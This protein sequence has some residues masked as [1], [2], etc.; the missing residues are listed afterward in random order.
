MGLANRFRV[1]GL[2]TAGQTYK[3]YK[4][5]GIK[6]W[7]R[8]RVDLQ[9]ILE[10]RIGTMDLT[11]QEHADAS[12]SQVL[13]AAATPS[14][15]ILQP[16]RTSS[17]VH[18]VGGQASV[19]KRVLAI[20]V[21]DDDL[22]RKRAKSYSADGGRCRAE[23]SS[24]PSQCGGAG[25]GAVI[26]AH[27]IP[28][29]PPKHLLSRLGLPSSFADQYDVRVEGFR[30]VT[31]PAGGASATPMHDQKGNVQ[32]DTTPAHVQLGFPS[33]PTS[34]DNTLCAAEAAFLYAGNTYPFSNV[35]R[36]SADLT[37]Q[38]Q[39]RQGMSSSPSCM[40]VSCASKSE[41]GHGDNTDTECRLRVDIGVADT[42]VPMDVAS[43]VPFSGPQVLA[44]HASKP[45]N[46]GVH[47]M[48]IEYIQLAQEVARLREERDAAVMLAQQM[49]DQL[50]RSCGIFGLLAMSP[51]AFDP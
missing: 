46:D 5:I 21:V 16:P 25:A 34:H 35:A 49:Q 17:S 30:D 19:G 27:D 4:V 22:N 31:P 40:S 23:G 20:A 9:S 38:H 2:W 18:S 36:C 39:S 47:E 42:G 14:D 45:S 11:R 3:L 51:E 26:R 7:C 24:R 44:L 32:A 1:C 43:S 48:P 28:V 13:A 10:E 8:S 37:L 15:S 29:R 33:I 6:T 50:E 41:A 12:S